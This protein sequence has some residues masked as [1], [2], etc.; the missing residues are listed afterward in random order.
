M[1]LIVTIRTKNADPI[2]NGDEFMWSGSVSTS[3]LFKDIH[4][5]LNCPVNHFRVKGNLKEI[6][7]RRGN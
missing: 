1:Y 7:T 6:T 3:R 4:R 5:I 2:K